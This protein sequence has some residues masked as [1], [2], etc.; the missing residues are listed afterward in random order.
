[1]KAYLF[2]A[3]LDIWLDKEILKFIK[4]KLNSNNYSIINE[5]QTNSHTTQGKYLSKIIG[6]EFIFNDIRV[7]SENTNHYNPYCRPYFYGDSSPSNSIEKRLTVIESDFDNYISSFLTRKNQNINLKDKISFLI[8]YVRTP[9]FIM[10][11]YESFR[12]LYKVYCDNMWE[13]QQNISSI[14]ERRNFLR[15]SFTNNELIKFNKIIQKKLLNIFLDYLEKIKKIGILDE[16]ESKSN[17]INEIKKLGKDSDLSIYYRCDQVKDFLGKI[18]LKIH[19]ILNN[20]YEIYLK[21]VD[22]KKF[23]NNF[24][25]PRVC[26]QYTLFDNDNQI[27]FMYFPLTSKELIIFINKSIVLPEVVL[28]DIINNDCMYNNMESDEFIV[29]KI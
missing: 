24:F 26:G 12:P 25:I 16:N 20:D 2:S 18:C 4:E 22:L 23:S 8:C 15:Q 13:E 6:K 28:N 14:V 10:Q 17:I 9:N 5:R 1:M 19:N 11:L 29:Q 7:N 27:A 3:Y 21:D